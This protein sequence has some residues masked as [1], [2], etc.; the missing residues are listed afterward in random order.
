MEPCTLLSKQLFNKILF[1]CCNVFVFQIPA[2][3]TRILLNHFKWDK[4]KL[5]EWYVNAVL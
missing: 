3:V 5:I 1:V 4:E 2:T